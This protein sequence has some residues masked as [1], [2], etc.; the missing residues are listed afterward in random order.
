M[1]RA[2]PWSSP[3]KA[4]FATIDTQSIAFA[5]II[6][7]I[8]AFF[9]ATIGL[10]LIS[11]LAKSFEGADGKFV[12]LANYAHVV[13]SPRFIASIKN[14]LLVSCSTVLLVI[15]IAYGYAYAITRT[16]VPMRATFRLVALMPLLAPTMLPAIALV[17]LFGNQGVA[18]GALFGATLYGPI[19]IV[20][21]ESIYTF[22]HATLILAT[23]LS[24]ADARLYEAAAS[25]KTSP[26]RTFL[27]VTIPA[28]K[29]GL[30]SASIVVFTL[31]VTDFGIPRVVG[32]QFSVFATDIYVNVVGIRDFETAAVI[33]TVLLVPALISFFVDWLVKKRQQAVL[34]ARSVPLIPKPQQTRDLVAFIYCLLVCGVILTCFGMAFFAS[35]VT[36]WPYN[37]NLTFANYDFSAKTD[38]GWQAYTNSLVMSG[39]AAAIGTL[40]VFSEGYL[41]EK[42]RGF[43][44]ARTLIHGFAMLP[45]AVPGV[46]LGLAYVLFFNQPANPLNCLIGTMTIMVISCIVHFFTVA[47]L[48]ALT[49]LKQIDSEFE[50]VAA[51]LKLSPFT[52][53]YRVTAPVS[54]PVILD[55]SVYLFLTS[56]TTVSAIVFLYWPQTMT[57]SIQMLFQNDN[58]DLAGA[59]ALGMMIVFTSLLVRIVHWLMTR[60]V[61]TVVQRWR[62]A[63]PSS[64]TSRMIG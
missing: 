44:V 45:M 54:L 64:R 18:K 14:S 2:E 3:G 58:G 63:S 13:G 41:V 19:G 32:G 50:S 48:T 5:A 37:L 15:P 61:L 52:L 60:K 42:V 12:A 24:L 25:L 36:F 43:R 31:S 1:M 28:T 34:S 38:I 53:V 26:L 55:V 40:F 33:G 22:P 17:Y 23:A 10:P 21:A 11:F 8:L 7:V 56:M 39:L 9:V 20:L 27:S 62:Q 6:V 59:A 35:I 46:V 57:A 49:A 30:V 4:S 29:F 47:H 51:S 16:R